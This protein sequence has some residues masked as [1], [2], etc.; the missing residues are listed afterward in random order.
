MRRFLSL[1]CL[2]AVDFFSK[3]WALNEVPLFRGGTYPFG[4]IGVFSDFGGISFS[5]NRVFNTGGAWGVFSGHP[6]LFFW[7]RL[8]IIVFF[9]LY[10]LFSKRHLLQKALLLILAGAIGNLFDYVLYGAV[11]DFFHFQFWGYSFPVFNLADVYIT[12]GAIGI[13][14]F[15]RHCC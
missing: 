6:K 5:L 2:I 14:F 10:F 9:L 7:L 4:G 13:L 12:L 8:L 11:I 3:H 1:L 15:P